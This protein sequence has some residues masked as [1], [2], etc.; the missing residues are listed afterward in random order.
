MQYIL[1]ITVKY[2][3]IRDRIPNSTGAKSVEIL[4]ELFHSSKACPCCCLH[5]GFRSRDSDAFRQQCIV[6]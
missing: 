1:M 5:S 2:I 4:Y 6:T 3:L